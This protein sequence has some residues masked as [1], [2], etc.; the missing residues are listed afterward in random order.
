MDQQSWV[1]KPDLKRVMLLL[2]L[3][4]FGIGIAI[5]GLYGLLLFMEVNLIADLALAFEALDIQ[6]SIDVS[7]LVIG[8]AFIVL[9]V[10]SL[11]F[12][13]YNKM[14]TFYQEKY[15]SPSKEEIP[16]E[17]VTRIIYKQDSVGQN[18]LGYGTV[19]IEAS[20]TD[21]PSFEIPFIPKPEQTTQQL[22]GL[23]DRYKAYRAQQEQQ[24]SRVQNILN[25]W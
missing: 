25:Q 7:K 13:K 14:H 17:N 4:I 18:V 21:A 8:G 6:I 12:L 10:Y 11:M 5:I 16:F 1:I 19:V 24:Q 2:S 23:V 9:I 22:Q 3:K 15:I 20:M